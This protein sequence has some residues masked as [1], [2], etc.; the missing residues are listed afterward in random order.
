MTDAIKLYD[1]ARMLCGKITKMAINGIYPSGEYTSC[2][3]MVRGALLDLAQQGEFGLVKELADHTTRLLDQSN[4]PSNHSEHYIKH[5]DFLYHIQV[6]PSAP[7]G[8]I[9]HIGFDRQTNNLIVESAI[10][11]RGLITMEGSIYA[12][13]MMERLAKDDDV[14]NWNKVADA[15]LTYQYNTDLVLRAFSK[16][17]TETILNNKTSFSN[18]QKNLVG[19]QPSSLILESGM[20]KVNEIELLDNLSAIG[21]QA[22][23]QQIALGSYDFQTPF[24]I[25][26]YAHD[27]GFKPDNDYLQSLEKRCRPPAEKRSATLCV[28]LYAYLLTTGDHEIEMNHVLTPEQ[29]TDILSMDGAETAMGTITYDKRKTGHLIDA[30]MKEVIKGKGGTAKLSTYEKHIPK[31][32]LMLSNIYKGMQLSDQIGL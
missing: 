5:E 4:M 17:K 1:Q 30:V 16:F 3:D 18:L 32:I 10:K 11:S 28:S 31:N 9:N 27:Y 21:E 24:K 29:L 23:I 14:T 12:F 2:V 25:H 20:Q 26:Q 8:L 7:S 6:F 19:F 13:R 22:L 15:L